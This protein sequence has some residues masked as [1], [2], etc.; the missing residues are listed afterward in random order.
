MGQKHG[1][2]ETVDYYIL[3]KCCDLSQNANFIGGGH[4]WG[5]EGKKESKN[6]NN[7]H[8]HLTN[9]TLRNI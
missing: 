4:G 3:I 8:S 2:K 7:M 9:K 1:T 5:E 6:K